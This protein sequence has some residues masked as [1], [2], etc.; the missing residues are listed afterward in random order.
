MDAFSKTPILIEKSKAVLS[1]FNKRDA[2]FKNATLRIRPTQ[3]NEG[4]C[5]DMLI[6]AVSTEEQVV[7][8][9]HLERFSN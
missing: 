1:F 6:H 2:H 4:K 9:L 7:I 5:L 8:C 3:C